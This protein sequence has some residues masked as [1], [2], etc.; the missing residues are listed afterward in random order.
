MNSPCSA[1]QATEPREHTACAGQVRGRPLFTFPRLGLDCE[2]NRHATPA[3]RDKR[4]FPVFFVMSE[5]D[6]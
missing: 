4:S 6:V 2:L 3:N 1:L 5:S